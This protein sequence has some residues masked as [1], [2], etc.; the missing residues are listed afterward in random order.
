MIKN[1]NQILELY[2]EY[3]A[4]INKIHGLYLDGL[5]GFEMILN[6]IEKEQ[7]YIRDLFAK[8]NPIVD[9]K[10]IWDAV[11]FS[12]EREFSKATHYSSKKPNGKSYGGSGMHSTTLGEM[13]KRNEP[14]GDNSILLGN[15]C[16]VMLFEHWDCHFRPALDKALGTTKI[17]VSIWGDLRL[18][19][20]GILHNGKAK[21]EILKAEILRWYKPGDP[22]VID[23]G[24]FRDIIFQLVIFGNQLHSL[25][26]PRTIMR[27]PIISNSDG[28][29][30][31]TTSG[32]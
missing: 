10:L 27:I 30:K 5:L 26:L 14:A 3:N 32:P 18:F 7:G 22:I 28:T 20:N 13:N 21:K 8:D 17:P 12:H 15:M 6:D 19:R 24:K 4:F 2:E 9:N 11:H 31:P 23:Q 25:S 29:T 1:L 16:V